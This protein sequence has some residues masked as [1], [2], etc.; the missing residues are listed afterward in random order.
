MIGWADRDRGLLKQILSDDQGVS[1][2]CPGRVRKDG[3]SVLLGR[4]AYCIRV[5]TPTS[6]PLDEYR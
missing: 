3:E 1:A 4:K 5:L 2:P 6:V